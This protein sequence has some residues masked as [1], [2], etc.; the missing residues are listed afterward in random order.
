V[1]RRARGLEMR[2]IAHD[3]FVSEE[4]AHVLGTGLVSLDELLREADFISVH[5]ALTPATQKMLGE[6][7]FRIVK[8]SVRIVNTARGGLIDEKALHQAVEE[9]RVA[10][11]AIDVFPKE[12]PP[13]DSPLLH[14]DGIIV[15]PHLGAST[16]EAQE[17]VAIDVAHEVLAVLSGQPATY[18]VNA[19]LISA[20]SMS[21]VAPYLEVAEKTAS[22]ATQLS[23]GQLGNVEIEYQGEIASQ[24]VTPL[25]AAVI[26]GLLLPISEENVTIVNAGLV[27]ER[28]GLKITERMGPVEEPYANLLS[29]GLTTSEGT[30]KV[31][32]TS[33]HDGAHIVLINDFWVDVP[34]GD[35]YLLLCE[36]LD[37]PGMVGAVGTFLGQHDINI[38]FMRLGRK[39]VRGRAL[40][41]LG[42]DDT[43]SPELLREMEAIQD[44][45]SARVVRI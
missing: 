10:G 39:Q 11:A 2:V 22:L 7:Q 25:R 4:R 29:V 5:A 42:L 41:V 12:P 35:G 33:A 31:A 18:A 30:T 32:G 26:R 28:R 44:V 20:E 14:S 13:E 19:P 34:P 24:D 37:R 17:R 16:T 36:N 21:V 6:E 1:A 3:P 15:T 9:G 40:M 45:Y 8:P 27:A 23:A 38:S 43:I